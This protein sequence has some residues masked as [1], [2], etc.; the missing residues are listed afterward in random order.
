MSRA[1]PNERA[2]PGE[3]GPSSLKALDGGDF[4]NSGNLLA[5][6]RFRNRPPENQ[7]PTASEIDE[8]DV[9]PDWVT[10]GDTEET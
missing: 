8:L 2:P 3:Q 10:A 7:Q 4:E 9:A 6:R 1:P 5:Q